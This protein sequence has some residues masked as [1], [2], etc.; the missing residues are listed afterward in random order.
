MMNTFSNIKIQGISTVVPKKVEENSIYSDFLAEKEVKKQCEFTGISKRHVCNEVQTLASLCHKASERL[1]EHLNWGTE[2]IEVLILV[3]QTPDFQ[4]PSLSFLLHKW[5]GLKK[6]C[7]VFDMNIGCSGFNVGSHTMSALLQGK[8]L[9]SKGLLL[10][11]EN[12]DKLFE[13]WEEDPEAIRIRM[14]FG[15]AATATAFEVAESNSISSVVLSDGSGYDTIIKR[16][17][18]NLKM[19][20]I[21]VYDFATNDVVDSIEQFIEHFNIK[22][23]EIDYY[24]FHQAQKAIIDELK[25]IRGLSE[26]N[27]L[28]S[29]EEYGNTLGV[30]VPLTICANVKSFPDEKSIRFLMCG[31]GMGLSWGIMYAEIERFNILPIYELDNHYSDESGKWINH[32]S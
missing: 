23:E 28:T 8:P 7:I 32:N 17:C 22:L 1:L 30:S 19:N 25:D 26:D 2:Q 16:H 24:I 18:E 5:L 3:T 13:E 9:G 11:G 14:L 15:C 10:C 20:G 12:I 6:D 29:Y 4:L 21:Q 27:V 31:F